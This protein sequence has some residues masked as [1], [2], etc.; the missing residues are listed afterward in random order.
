MAPKKE[1]MVKREDVQCQPV[2]KPYRKAQLTVHGT[3]DEIT[4]AK[5]LS[6]SDGVQRGHS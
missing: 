4:S 3:L 5:T 2:R 6:P 1:D